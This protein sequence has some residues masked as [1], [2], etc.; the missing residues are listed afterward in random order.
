MYVTHVGTKEGERVPFTEDGTKVTFG[1]DGNS[2]TVDVEEI[3]QDSQVSFDIMQDDEGKLGT[4]GNWYAATL[5]IPPAK[6][7]TVEDRENYTVNEDGEK[8]YS[9]IQRKIPLDMGAVEVALYPLE[10]PLEK[11]EEGTEYT[12]GMENP[13][14][15]G[16][17]EN[18][19]EE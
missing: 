9:T 2:F 15:A 17:D 14:E 11:K 7:E 3:Q 18:K 16:S 12:G 1:I 5:T 4:E 19:E 8:E 6:Y 13:A 10:K